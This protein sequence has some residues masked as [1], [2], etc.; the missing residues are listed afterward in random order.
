MKQV[1]PERTQVA[2]RERLAAEN[3][4]ERSVIKSWARDARIL[5]SLTSIKHRLILQRSTPCYGNRLERRIHERKD[6][7]PS[8][9]PEPTPSMNE[10]AWHN[11]SFE[12][13][14]VLWTDSEP[15]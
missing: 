7:N 3:S 14:S 4:K 8:T 1:Y 12:V 6:A 11:S 2:R 5:V 15:G 13:V 9:S 10:K